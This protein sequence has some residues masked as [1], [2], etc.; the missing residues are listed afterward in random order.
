MSDPPEIGR[1]T[2]PRPD[3]PRV[4]ERRS[5]TQTIVVV[6]VLAVL[7]VF[8][9]VGLLNAGPT[10][11][12]GA[13]GESVSVSGASSGVT[14]AGGGN[15][16]APRPKHSAFDIRAVCEGMVK[17]RLVSPRSAKIL[18][19]SRDNPVFREGEWTW[20][21]Q[22]ESQNAFGVWL[23]TTFRCNTL[24]DQENVYVFALD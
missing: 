8:G 17:E 19:S 18:T 21:V 1:P 7:G 4:P 16:R 13:S 10:S 20:T 23:R 11:V 5:P 15:P 14:A 9:M 24:N 12:T 3:Q 2:R 6:G 22:V